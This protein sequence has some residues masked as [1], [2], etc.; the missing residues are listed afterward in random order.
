MSVSSTTDFIS[1]CRALSAAPCWSPLT[2]KEVEKS[3]KR[4]LRPLR[5]P[6]QIIAV[7][8]VDA[9]QMGQRYSQQKAL[10]VEIH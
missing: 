6:E 3:L 4:R 8:A 9:S 5:C 2:M 10:L 1:H 7:V